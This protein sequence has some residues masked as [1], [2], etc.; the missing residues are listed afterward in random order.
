MPTDISDMKRNYRT[1]VAGDFPDE[2]SIGLARD[3]N[4]QLRYGENPMQSA[5]V[6]GFRSKGISLAELTN[7]RLAKT[8][9]GGVSAINLMDVLRA[10]DVLKYFEKPAVAVMKHNI[11]SGFA[12]QCTLND[13]TLLE[14]Y[15]NARD[16]DARSAFGSVVVFNRTVDKDTANELLETYVE[17][18]AAPEY[19]EGVM[20]ILEQKKDLRVMQFSNLDRLPKFVGDDTEGLYDMKVLPTGR[21][22]VQK[23]YLTSIKSASD[24]VLDAMVMDE[25]GKEHVVNRKP[26]EAELEDMLTAW[27]VNFG[28]RSNGIV[29][30]CD[31]VTVAVG[32]GQQE[33]IGAVEQALEKGFKKAMDREG[34]KYTHYDWFRHIEE[35]DVY[36][37]FGSVCSSDAF[38]PF[39]DSIDTMA[40][41]SVIGA[42]Q[43]GGSKKDSEVIDAVNEHGMVAAFTLERCFGHF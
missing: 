16:A 3:A 41:F 37:F 6:Y 9:K 11:P 8:G 12:T 34:I 22:V 24:L 40:E 2:L 15:K 31:G 28:V 19:H 36:P 30:V 21:V 25:R 38:F 43:P 4:L 13:K 10:M 17:G 26:G 27:Y 7:V 33:R 14:L 23:P 20:G 35:L 5:A 42:I 18:V 1:A 32:S 39:R 29:F